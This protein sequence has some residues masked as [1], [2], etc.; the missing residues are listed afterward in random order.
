[1]TAGGGEGQ[2]DSPDGERGGEEAQNGEWKRVDHDK[3]E[4]SKCIVTA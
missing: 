4:K 2:T 3:Q 1:M